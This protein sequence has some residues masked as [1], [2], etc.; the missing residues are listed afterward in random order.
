[1][2]KEWSDGNPGIALDFDY[3]GT[4][5]EV[6][7]EQ[8]SIYEDSI[9]KSLW[10]GSTP[11]SPLCLEPFVDAVQCLAGR[12]ANSG[13]TVGLTSPM[14]AARD[15]FKEHS[16][17]RDTGVI[18]GKQHGPPDLVQHCGAKHPGVCQQDLKSV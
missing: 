16:Y 15:A 17:C 18:P 5:L 9:G 13:I 3:I 1:M 11:A 12:Q 10:R 8:A 4:L 14:A 6:D 2:R 7:A